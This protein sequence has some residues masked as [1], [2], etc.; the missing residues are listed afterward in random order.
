MRRF[1]RLSALSLALS[2]LALTGLVRAADKHEPPIP[3]EDLPQPVLAAVKKR[4]PEAKLQNAIK[5]TEGDHTFFEVT[6]KNKAHEVYVVCDP[7]GKIVEIDRILTFK[8]LPKSVQQAVQKKHPKS[9]ILSVEEVADEEHEITYA[10]LLKQ[11]QKTLHMLLDP[12]GKL[13]EE[14]AYEDKK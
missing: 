14:E 4:F 1:V 12:K 11:G 13:I 10:V 9:S 5:D 2:W 3:L 7:D 6:L 8:E